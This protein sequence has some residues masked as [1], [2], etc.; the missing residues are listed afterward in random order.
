LGVFLAFAAHFTLEL[1]S[2]RIAAQIA[3]SMLGIVIMVASAA[4]MAWYKRVEGKSS[5]RP[6]VDAD[7]AGG[8]A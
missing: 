8:E 6:S 2:S 4:L 5:G 1:V 7:L 3:L